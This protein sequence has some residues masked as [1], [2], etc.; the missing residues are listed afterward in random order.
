MSDRTALIRRLDKAFSRHIR[1]RDGHRCVLC[2]S[3][4]TPECGH[5]FTRAA[6]STRWSEAN[7][8][9]VCHA[10]NARHE[11]DDTAHTDWFI[12]THGEEAYDNLLRLHN[13]VVHFTNDDLRTMIDKLEHE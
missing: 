7:C 11:E 2:G 12:A 9:C 8:A 10:C 4:D 6:M 5:L 3:C 1:E 13:T